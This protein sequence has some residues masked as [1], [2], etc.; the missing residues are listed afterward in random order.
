MSRRFS[1]RRIVI[2]DLEMYGSM[3]KKRGLKKI[4][5]YETPTIYH[6][7]AD[8]MESLNLEAHR[9][10]V[11]DRFY[12]LAD[13]YYNNPRLWWVIAQFNKT[14]TESHVGLGDLVYIPLPLDEIMRLYGL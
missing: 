12:K 13:E 9:W 14:P 7:T 4:Y 2:N 11:G 10:T 8:E 3:L 1:T 5:Q 6:P